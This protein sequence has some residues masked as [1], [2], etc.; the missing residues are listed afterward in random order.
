M[1]LRPENSGGFRGERETERERERERESCL[2]RAGKRFIMPLHPWT[3][4]LGPWNFSS[5]H[6]SL[7]SGTADQTVFVGQDRIMPALDQKLKI[8]ML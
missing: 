3:A 4:P 1:K 6:T 5:L 8:K 2:L 7:G